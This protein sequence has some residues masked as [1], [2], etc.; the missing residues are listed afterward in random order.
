MS[1]INF[2]N[3]LWNTNYNFEQTN[4]KS[5]FSLWRFIL[6]GLSLTI[7]LMYG[8]EGGLLAGPAAGEHEDNGA[9]QELEP[10]H[11]QHTQPDPR[12]Q[13]EHI[14]AHAMIIKQMWS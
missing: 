12:V 8:K 14:Q 2:N 3:I 13:A 4:E 10:H 6:V 11:P 1:S 7:F 9:S 5:I